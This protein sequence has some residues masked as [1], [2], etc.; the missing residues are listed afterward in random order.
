MNPAQCSLVGQGSSQTALL[1]SYH[2]WVTNR[3]A[4]MHKLAEALC[5]RGFRVGFV[6]EGRSLHNLL[7]RPDDR[8]CLRPFLLGLKG[9]C[10]R[11][12]SGIIHHFSALDL[13][14]P[15]RWFPFDHPTARALRNWS[16]CILMR[17]CQ[18]LFPDPR[19]IILESTG[20]I[21]LLNLLKKTYP[22][23]PILYR[24]S[25][26]FPTWKV[27]E[28]VRCALME[29]EKCVIREVQLT[30]LPDA[31]YEGVY[32]SLGYEF[33]AMPNNPCV[34]E[35]GIDLQAFKERHPVP[36]A[37]SH[38][39]PHA[40]YVGGHRPDYDCIIHCAQKLPEI[41]FV[42]V[43]PE[44]PR[45]EQERQIRVLDNMTYVPGVPPEQVPA[46]I[47]NATVVMIAYARCIPNLHSKIL[48]AMAASKPIIAFGIAPE[49]SR[50][51]FS[52][53]DSY[54]SF[55]EMVAK[56]V[57]IPSVKYDYDLELRD[58]SVFK[59]TFLSIAEKAGIL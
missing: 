10:Y 22:D 13:Q 18:R 41:H 50:L 29:M 15:Q 37:L 7:L 2:N 4:G 43:C 3:V 34:L 27:P 48:Q 30:L 51:G 16:H 1:F 44:K 40:C 42:V 14:V 19:L 25:D 24:P 21:Y 45:R 59:A 57:H 17:R 28:A 36:V 23:V 52:V 26:P 49:L 11:V 12:S 47:T 38:P 55:V 33:R 9:C 35:N 32:R 6:N 31:M 53:A 20:V 58:W 5:D 39:R 8:Y 46:Y 54:S 56:A